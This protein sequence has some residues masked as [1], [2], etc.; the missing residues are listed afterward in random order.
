MRGSI[1][2]PAPNENCC[3]TGKSVT[4]SH[5]ETASRRAAHVQLPS[6][7]KTAVLALI[8]P[9]GHRQCLSKRSE[10][11]ATPMQLSP[12]LSG[13]RSS[14]DRDDRCC[15]QQSVT[16]RQVRVGQAPCG[17]WARSPRS[18]LSPQCR[19]PNV[20]PVLDPVELVGVDV[21]LAHLFGKRSVHQFELCNE[22]RTSNPGSR[23]MAARINSASV[24][25]PDARIESTSRKSRA[26]ARL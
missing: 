4:F 22:P 19:R 9:T 10:P 7:D 18:G 23:S 1:P 12:R 15:E 3:R 24:N 21:V 2:L 5:A 20:E 11:G 13:S 25:F 17:F 26:Y 16:D 6:A 14:T 8:G